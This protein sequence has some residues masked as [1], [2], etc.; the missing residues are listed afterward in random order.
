MKTLDI[1]V[2]AE[3]KKKETHES[4]TCQRVPASCQAQHH[5]RNGAGENPGM[6]GFIGKSFREK[7]QFDAKSPHTK[8]V[9][10]IHYL[11][12]ITVLW[13]WSDRARL[14]RPFNSS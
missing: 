5:A 4:A 3:E 6:G 11:A 12:V 2:E 9:P 14:Q 8:T 13:P 1:G 10:M 7:H